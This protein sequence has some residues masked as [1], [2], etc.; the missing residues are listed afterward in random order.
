[1][2]KSGLERQIQNLPTDVKFCTKCVMSNQRPRITLDDEGVCGGCRNTEFYKEN[3]DWDAREQELVELL[4]K[5]RSTD[6]SYDVVVPSSGGKDSAFVAHQLKYKYGMNPLTVTWAP[7]IYT[8]IGQQN[9][10]SMRDAGFTNLL[11]SP[12]GQL[13]RDLARFSFEEFGDAFHVFVLGQLSYAFHIA[14]KFGIKLVMF[15]ENGEAEYAGDPTVADRPFVPASEFQRLYFKGASLEE[16]IEYARNNTDYFNDNY[17]QADLDFYRPPSQEELE[18][19]GIEGKH[20][21]GYYKKW[22]PQEN[23]YYA[24]QHTGFEANPER[25]EGTYSKYASLDDKLDGMHYFMK[26]IKFGFGRTTDDASHEVRDG[27]IDRDEA[28]A[29]VKKYDGEF[30]AKYFPEFLDYLGITEEHFWHVVDS[31]RL[32]HIWKKD[33]S[34]E[35]QLKVTVD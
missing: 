27:H 19:V 11:C 34:G 21:F 22:T 28:I 26:F 4:D 32:D 17:S 8:D 15:G 6:G 31:Y 23:Y 2:R 5:H 16:T 29:L 20:F 33:D 18:R 12:N 9:F 24:S 13:H 3:T 1:M 14:V 35:W 7:L 10:Q 25:T 30:P